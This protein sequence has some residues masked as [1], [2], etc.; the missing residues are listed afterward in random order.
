MG[1]RD[2]IDS[3]FDLNKR[4]FK[5]SD[6][7]LEGVRQFALINNCTNVVI[8][9]RLTIMENI[10][11]KKG[12]EKVA[13]VAT[14]IGNSLTC[15]K[16]WLFYNEYILNYNCYNLIDINKKIMDDTNLKIKDRS[17]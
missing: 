12:F 9:N 3:T 8:T 17:Y 13:I 15:P 4:Q 11:L 5:V 2:R 7:L 6:A 1:I 10:L 14:H 16:N